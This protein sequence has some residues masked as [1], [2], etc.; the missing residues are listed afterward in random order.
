MRYV[1]DSSIPK[2]CS[3][4]SR[5]RVKGGQEVSGSVLYRMRAPPWSEFGS[6]RRDR[7]M[8]WVLPPWGGGGACFCRP[9]TLSFHRVMV[10]YPHGGWGVG[11]FG[12]LVW[13]THPGQTIHQ[14]QTKTTFSLGKNEILKTEPKLRG[15]F[16]VHKLFFAL[17]PLTPA[18]RQLN[19][20]HNSAEQLRFPRP[21]RTLAV[22]FWCR[23]GDGEIQCEACDTRALDARCS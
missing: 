4:A 1:Y 2:C 13:R 19:T 7:A 8:C 9:L 5:I 16:R 3:L 18:S 10:S 6:W 15:P 22:C 12:G 14:P 11:G 20:Q 21:V 17:T 23:S